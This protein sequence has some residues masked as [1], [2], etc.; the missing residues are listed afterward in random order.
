MRSFKTVMTFQRLKQ[1]FT[2]SFTSKE[3]QPKFQQK[4]SK[5][6]SRISRIQQN[7]QKHFKKSWTISNKTT[8]PWI[9]LN[10]KILVRRLPLPGLSFEWKVPAAGSSGRRA[11]C[12]EL[13]P[14]QFCRKRRLNSVSS[15]HSIIMSDM[16]CRLRLGFTHPAQKALNLYQL[17]FSIPS[18]YMQSIF[19]LLSCLKRCECNDTNW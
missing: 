17:L 11:D 1:N 13:T 2:R 14:P 15:K 9:N 8:S 4:T 7:I 16:S 6:S 18:V 10:G 12:R 19:H 5:R 3:C